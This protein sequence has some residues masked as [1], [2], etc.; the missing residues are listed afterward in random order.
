MDQVIPLKQVLEGQFRKQN[1]A[2]L[3]HKGITIDFSDWLERPENFK[4]AMKSCDGSFHT[5]HSDVANVLSEH[6]KSIKGGKISEAVTELAPT[7]PI[8]GERFVVFFDSESNAFLIGNVET[9]LLTLSGR[10]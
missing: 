8:H 1:V 3:F 4:L 5:V 2:E 7:D 9:A 6:K 10:M